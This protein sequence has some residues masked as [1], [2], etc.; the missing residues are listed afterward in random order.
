MAW[1]NAP[2]DQL[3]A[4]GGWPGGT[5]YNVER[6]EEQVRREWTDQEKA[7][8]YDRHERLPALWWVQR[9]RWTDAEGRKY[10]RWWWDRPADQRVSL[11]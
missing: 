11:T 8:A 5:R 9:E 4:T 10:G 2:S 3:D 1:T 6:T 7:R